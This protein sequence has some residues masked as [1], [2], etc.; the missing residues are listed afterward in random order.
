MP[1][2]VKD[3]RGKS[4]V[5]KRSAKVGERRTSVALEDAFWVALKD[6]AAAQ[7]TPV[8]RLIATSTASAAR[9]I[10][11]ICRRQSVYSCSIITGVECGL[12]R[13]PGPVVILT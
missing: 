7:G 4:Q 6:I 3:P 13:G 9:A 1:N 5:V 10:T 11:P 8:R 12:E 2:R